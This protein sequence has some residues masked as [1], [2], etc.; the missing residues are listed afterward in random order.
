MFSYSTEF[1]DGGGTYFERVK[2]LVIRLTKALDERIF[3]LVVGVLNR[4][5]C[6]AGI[7]AFI[8]K[9]SYTKCEI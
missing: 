3:C 2:L 8:N 4:E 1:K 5:P 7:Q 6:D 9:P